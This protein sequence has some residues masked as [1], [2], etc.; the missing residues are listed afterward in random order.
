MASQ[1]GY[2]PL[3]LFAFVS[4]C[5]GIPHP[6]DCA[7]G[8]TLYAGYRD[9][10]PYTPGYYIQHPEMAPHPLPPALAVE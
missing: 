2:A 7:L 5:A 10:N 9:L 3:L 6:V 1:M 8:I 4:L